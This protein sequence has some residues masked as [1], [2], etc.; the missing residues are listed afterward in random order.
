MVQIEMFSAYPKMLSPIRNMNHAKK[1]AFLSNLNLKICNI[2]KTHNQNAH[3]AQLQVA[4]T[5][6]LQAEGQGCK[7]IP[8]C[9]TVSGHSHNG[10]QV[11][12]DLLR[13]GPTIT[14]LILTTVLT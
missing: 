8:Q 14:A 4:D 5:V 9:Q 6:Y 11:V 1:M 10:L 2:G 7:L 13:P 12:I 3:Y